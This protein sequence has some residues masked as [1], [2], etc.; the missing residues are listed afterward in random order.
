MFRVESSRRASRGLTLIELVVVLAILVVLG[1]LLVQN[2]PNF[3]KRTHL[4]KCA[5][6]IWSLNST[7]NQS[8]SSNIRYPDVY[9][10][11]LSSGG[12]ALDPRLAAGLRNQ[13]EMLE[14]TTTDVAAL[15]AVGV[16]RVIDLGTVPT[17]GSV[18]YDA[19]P[20][21]ATARVLASGGQVV[22]LNLTA[23]ETAG[24]VLQLKRHLLRQ[25]DGSM[26]DDRTNVRYLVF[27]LGP[28]CTAV[29]S[30][31]RIQEAPVHFASDDTINP[32]TVYQRYLII[33]SLVTDAQGAVTA[34]YEAAA[35]N[36]VTGPSSGEAHIRQFH[37][38]ASREG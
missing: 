16:T 30:G 29:G 35:G 33:M 3:M 10:S 37:E 18:T 1:G 27:G 14:L 12:S 8:Y 13:C 32:S 38:S 20:L 4:A 36:D 9:D 25:S 23:H 24:N 5:D 26:L 7:W 15:R 2:L 6:T 17:G 11:L 28:N 34:Y 31:K 22:R 19:A 21:G